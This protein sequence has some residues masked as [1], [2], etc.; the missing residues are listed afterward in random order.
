MNVKAMAAA[1][2]ATVI[3][4]SEDALET[5]ILGGYCGDLLSWVMGRATEGCAWVTLMNNPN[6]AAVAHLSGVACVILA[7]DVKPDEVLLKKAEA[8]DIPILASALQA[9]ELCWKIH[10]AL[11]ADK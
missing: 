10:Q 9:Y 7:E 5:K 1:L 4:G 3:C 6:V 11:E 8:E 2:S